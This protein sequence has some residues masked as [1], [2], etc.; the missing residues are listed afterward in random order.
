LERKWPAERLPVPID[1]G[2]SV[3]YSGSSL[4][5]KDD[6]SANRCFP[7]MLRDT[8]AVEMLLTGEHSTLTDSEG[9]VFVTNGVSCSAPALV[10]QRIGI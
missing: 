10:I 7:D 4:L 5:E 2:L 8:F 6:G 9:I 1:S 3:V